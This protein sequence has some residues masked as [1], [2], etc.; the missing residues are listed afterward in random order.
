MGSCTQMPVVLRVRGCVQWIYMSW[1]PL[2]IAIIGLVAIVFIWWWLLRAYR[3]H[4]NTA[5]YH[6]DHTYTG[7]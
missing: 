3:E 4:R 6:D 7:V 1:M 2:I 5:E